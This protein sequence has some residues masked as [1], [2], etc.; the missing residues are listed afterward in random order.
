MII[1]KA[2]LDVLTPTPQFI[3]PVLIPYGGEIMDALGFSILPKKSKEYFEKFC[4]Q[5]LRHV[6]FQLK[7]L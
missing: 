6:L 5:I 3:I 1:F 4:R 7:F 2:M